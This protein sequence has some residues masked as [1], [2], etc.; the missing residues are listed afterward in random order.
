MFY[1]YICLFKVTGL[2]SSLYYSKLKT[3]VLKNRLEAVS[4]Q[5]IQAVVVGIYLH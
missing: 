1:G 4:H 5:P 2:S 3:T